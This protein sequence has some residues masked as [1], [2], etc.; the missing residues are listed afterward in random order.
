V[1]IKAGPIEYNCKIPIQTAKK[2]APPNEE[3]NQ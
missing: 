3:N 2:K 1:E